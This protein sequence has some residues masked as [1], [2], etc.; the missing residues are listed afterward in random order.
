MPAPARPTAVCLPPTGSE[1][2]ERLLIRV[3]PGGLFPL[4][5]TCDLGNDVP[6]ETVANRST[7][8]ACGP[9]VDQALATTDPAKRIR[10]GRSGRWIS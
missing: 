5:R 10:R 9:N 3:L 6:L 7:P 8:M 2:D 1:D 4:D